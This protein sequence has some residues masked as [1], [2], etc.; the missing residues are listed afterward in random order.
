MAGP[1]LYPD[2]RTGLNHPV[3]PLPRTHTMSTVPLTHLKKKLR[4]VLSRKIPSKQ[5]LLGFIAVIYTSKKNTNYIF[6]GQNGL[7]VP[8]EANMY[9]PL[10]IV[11]ANRGVTCVRRLRV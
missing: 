1:Q 9:T 7:K 8:G 2:T 6:A 3:V 4:M 11:K 5:S 10:P